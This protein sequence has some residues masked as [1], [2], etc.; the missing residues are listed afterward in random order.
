M[1]PRLVAVFVVAAFTASPRIA[2]SAVITFDPGA[3]TVLE[4]LTRLPA[5]SDPTP[6]TT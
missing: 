4:M 6:S 3:G 5:D 1:R 2:L